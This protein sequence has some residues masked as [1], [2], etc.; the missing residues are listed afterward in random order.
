M[1]IGVPGQPEGR[2]L[3]D[4]TRVGRGW[5]THAPGDSTGAAFAYFDEFFD[6]R[7]ERDGMV[8]IHWRY[9]EWLKGQPWYRPD[10]L[11]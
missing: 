2:F 5:T 10:L 9:G 7:D 3:H 6:R 11:G 4:Q 1:E 8:R